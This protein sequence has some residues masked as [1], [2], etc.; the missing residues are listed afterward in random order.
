MNCAICGCDAIEPGFAVVPLVREGI[1][2]VFRDVP[3]MICGEC[4]EQYFNEETTSNLLAAA[5]KASMK[6]VDVS[7][8]RY[9]A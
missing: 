9:V 5:D 3:A 7:V 1:T 2:L 4:G 6:G 8:M